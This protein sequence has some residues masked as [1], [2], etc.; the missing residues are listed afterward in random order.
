MTEVHHHR[1]HRIIK[2]FEAEALRKR[3]LFQKIADLLSSYFGTV[4]F[5]VINAVVFTVWVLGN[6][7]K[8]PGFPI[9]DPYPYAFM[10]SFVSIE[11][12]ILTVIV[13]MSQNRENQRDV[14][15]NELGLQVQ[16]IAEREITKILSL[17]KEILAEQNKLKHDPE[18]EEMTE[19]IDTGYIERKLEEQLKGTETAPMQEIT[20]KIEE[21]VT[22][23][24]K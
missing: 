23:P 3:P 17:L 12:I 24:K 15:R 14:L 20:E 1:S 21:T 11:A 8:I 7:G 5:L 19:R 22:T 4:G 16:L 6:S 9:I 2:S 10:S 18:L 13:L